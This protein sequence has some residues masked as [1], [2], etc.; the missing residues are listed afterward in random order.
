MLGRASAGTT[1]TP[2]FRPSS[3]VLVMAFER[4]N[5][6]QTW[7]LV[8]LNL[9]ITR[10]LALQ[11]HIA[12]ILRGPDVSGRELYQLIRLQVFVPLPSL[13]LQLT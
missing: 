10:V 5:S 4:A 8:P 1:K 12:S 3:Q 11:L 13:K 6:A 7:R 2:M 9:H